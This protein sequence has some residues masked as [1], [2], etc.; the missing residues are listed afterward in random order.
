MVLHHNDQ[1]RSKADPAY[2]LLIEDIQSFETQRQQKT[3]SLNLEKRR[4]ERQSLDAERLEREN[5]N[6]IA[7]GKPGFKALEE[8]EAD[9][10]AE[11][12]ADKAPDILLDQTAQILADIVAVPRGGA[13]IAQE[14][15]A[16]APT[17]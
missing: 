6:R 16:P 1:A 7:Q 5:R 12:L 15:R 11:A 8:L 4:Q 2:R 13:T 9:N 10:N 3:L 14:R 17:P